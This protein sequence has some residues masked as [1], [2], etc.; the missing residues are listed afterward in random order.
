MF[1]NLLPNINKKKFRFFNITQCI[2]YALKGYFYL[3]W[4]EICG[5]N[6]QTL[7]FINIPAQ[8]NLC[9]YAY[10]V[11]IFCVWPSDVTAYHTFVRILP[12][13]D[14]THRALY[15]CD[16]N[17]FLPRIGQM[18]QALGGSQR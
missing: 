8:R 5:A 11:R 13:T 3:L 16:R 15:V 18:D 2:I 10:N 4:Y 12:E 14:R 7:T 6:Y 17:Y 9:V 1:I